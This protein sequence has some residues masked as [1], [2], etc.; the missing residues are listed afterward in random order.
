MFNVGGGELLVI[1]LLALI[2]LGPKR[3]PEAARQVGKVMGDIRRLSSGFQDE[4]RTAFDATEQERTPTSR[5]DVLSGPA[6]AEV[7]S[8]T[9]RA[10]ASVSELPV[11]P[12]LGDDGLDDVAEAESQQPPGA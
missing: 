5:R 2:V 10:I 11:A 1:S 8:S 3:L 12:A 7:P 6:A 4:V 9:A